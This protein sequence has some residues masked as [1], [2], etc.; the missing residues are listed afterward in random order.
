[1]VGD[2][3]VPVALTATTIFKEGDFHILE[4]QNVP[5]DGDFD[6]YMRLDVQK[7]QPL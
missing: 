6:F 4:P 1:M 2:D 3:I 7:I 5:Y